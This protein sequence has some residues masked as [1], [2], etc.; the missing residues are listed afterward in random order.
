MLAISHVPSVFLLLPGYLCLFSNLSVCVVDVGPPRLEVTVHISPA[1]VHLHII[2]VLEALWDV[3]VVLLAVK[4][5]P[6]QPLSLRA[7]LVVSDRIDTLS[8]CNHHCLIC[9][10]VLPD[11]AVYI[12]LPGAGERFAGFDGVVGLRR[13]TLQLIVVNLKFLCFVISH[14]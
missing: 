8:S 6:K 4:N 14:Y 11:T 5:Q 12:L 2:L 1:F 3:E 7:L 9:E 13:N 10:F